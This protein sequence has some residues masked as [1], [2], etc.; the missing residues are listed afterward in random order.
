M[1]LVGEGGE[2]I[3]YLS[4]TDQVLRGT[5]DTDTALNAG[6]RGELLLLNDR[7]M[8]LSRKTNSFCNTSH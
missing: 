5:R 6:L 3:S 7:T 2:E 4:D 8:P 1:T